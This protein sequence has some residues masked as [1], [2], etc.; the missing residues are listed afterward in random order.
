MSAVRTSVSCEELNQLQLGLTQQTF[1]HQYSS[2]YFAR[3]TALRPKVVSAAR[4]KWPNHLELDRV[5]DVRND[6]NCWVVGTAYMTSKLKPNVMD[7]VTQLHTIITAS[8]DSPYVSLENGNS[9][10]IQYSLEDNY[11]R[12]DCT[13]SLMYDVGVVTGVVMAALGHEDEAGRFVVID[14]C[15]PESLSNND[16]IPMTIDSKQEESPEFMAVVSGLGLSNDGIEGIGL[17]QIIEYLRG[18]LPSMSSTFDPS[19]IKRLMILGNCLAP[20]IEISDS[21]TPSVPVGKKKVKRYGYDT[22][23]YNPNPTIQLDTLLDQLCATID[24]TLIPGPY[25]YSTNILPQQPLHPALLQNAKAWIGNSLQT[26]TNPTWLSISDNLTLASSGQNINDLRKYHP[27]KSSLRL[28]ENTVLWNHITPTSPDTLWC[29]PFTDRDTFVMDELP[30]L[31]LCGNQPKFGTK[32]I[33]S[34]TKSIRL[35][36]VPEFRKTGI[37]TLINLRNLDVQAL[38]FPRKLDSSELTTPNV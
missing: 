3:L 11:G 30:N 34:E 25:D 9:D 38:V 17:H 8:E 12:V 24:V 26:T 14:V 2:I 6:Q 4:K 1:N 33:N 28:M 32:I 18:A 31:Y 23:S 27:H 15:F 36:S 5:L 21:S 35:V 13:G 7:D 16:T 20:A 19:S 37:I 22:S 10:E 29:Y